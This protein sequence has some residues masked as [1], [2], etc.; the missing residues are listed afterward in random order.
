MQGR[1]LRGMSPTEILRKLRESEG[2]Y[3]CN[4]ER[5]VSQSDFKNRLLPMT[6]VRVAPYREAAG[7][8][9]VEVS[10]GAS[11]HVDLMRK[12]VD[13]FERLRI[14]QKAMP[15][16]LLQTVCRGSSVFG[17]RHYP[18]NVIRLAV[19]EFARYVDVWRVYDFLNHVPNIVPVMDEI[20]KAG[21]LLMPS[22][23]FSTGPEHTDRYYVDKIREILQVTGPEVIISIKNYAGLGTPKRI[24]QLVESICAAFPGLVLHYHGCNTDGNDIGRMSAAVLAGAKICDVADHGYGA[25]YGQAPALTL[26][27]ALEDYNKKAVGVDIPALIQS[28]DLLRQERKIYEPFESPFRGHDPTVAAYKLT[29]GAVGSTFEQADKGGFLDRMPEILTEMARVQVELGNWWVVT[30]GSQI[31][32]TTAVNNVLYGR[33]ERPSLDLTNLLLGRYGPLPFFQPEAWIYEKVLEYQRYDGKKWQ[34]IL[35]DEAGI[36]KPGDVDLNMERRRLEGELDRRVNDEE[37]VLYLQFPFD[38]LSFFKFQARYGKVWM[39]PPEVWFRQGGFK[40]GER[41]TFADEFGVPHYIEVIS[42]RREGA[43][44]LTTLVVDHSF[45]SF[46]VQVE[47]ADKSAASG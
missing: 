36:Q 10:G 29:G 8:F 44:V 46:S 35:M 24:S 45:Q 11:V 37:L 20:Q 33:Y 13:P 6:T 19:R 4:N 12:Q 5:D 23:C 18:E 1:I 39:L 43:N 41:I 3:L 28:S 2:Y 40:D 31:L 21:R 25:I 26:I 30:P 38:A 27:Q 22:V 9:S 7:F 15:K 42:T 32:W 14:A 17:Y 16:T 34:Q 47:G